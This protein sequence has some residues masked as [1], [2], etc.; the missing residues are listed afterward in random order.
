MIKRAYLSY[1]SIILI[2]I[3]SCGS[4]GS[5]NS[6]NISPVESRKEL[7]ERL[8]LGFDDFSFLV[9]ERYILFHLDE[10]LGDV[11][12]TVSYIDPEEGDYRSVEMDKRGGVYFGEIPY[13]N[14]GTEAVVIPYR[15]CIQE[16]GGKLCF[17]GSKL[18][19]PKVNLSSESVK[20]MRFF[21]EY[22]NFSLK[23]EW[24][25]E[26]LDRILKRGSREYFEFYKGYPDIKI[27]VGYIVKNSSCW[28][29]DW[30]YLKNHIQ[31]CGVKYKE[32]RLEI[33]FDRESGRIGVRVI[34]IH[35][36]TNSDAD[37]IS[38]FINNYG[39]IEG[40]NYPVY[41][42]SELIYW[43]DSGSRKWEPYLYYAYRIMDPLEL[44]FRI[45][46]YPSRKGLFHFLIDMYETEESL[47]Y[48]M[49]SEDAVCKK[50]K[51]VINSNG[52]IGVILNPT[53]YC[54]SWG[55]A[56]GG[57]D[58]RR[59]FRYE[60]GSRCGVR[61]Y[62]SGVKPEHRIIDFMFPSSITEELGDYKFT[63]FQLVIPY[64][65][66]KTREDVTVDKDCRYQFR[67]TGY[68]TYYV[69]K[70][71][72]VF[73]VPYDPELKVEVLK[74]RG[75]RRYPYF[76]EDEIWR[77]KPWRYNKAPSGFHGKE[78][79]SNFMVPFAI[80]FLDR[81][82]EE[83]SEGTHVIVKLAESDISEG[84]HNHELFIE[85]SSG[86]G[87]NR[88][89]ATGFGGG[90]YMVDCDKVVWEL[91]NLYH[92]VG[93]RVIGKPGEVSTSY[94]EYGLYTRFECVI[95]RDGVCE[96][97]LGGKK[98]ARFC[99]VAGP[100]SGR[101]KL[102]A[103]TLD[104]KDKNGRPYQV[105]KLIEV[106]YHDLTPLTPEDLKVNGR[107]IGIR[108]GKTTEHPENFYVNS[109]IYPDVLFFIRQLHKD[110]YDDLGYPAILKI[111]D[112][113]LLWGGRFHISMDDMWS[114]DQ[115]HLSH[116][117]GTGMDILPTVC[118]PVGSIDVCDNPYTDYRRNGCIAGSV[119]GGEHRSLI[120]KFAIDLCSDKN[121]LSGKCYI[122]QEPSIHIEFKL[123]R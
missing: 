14:M 50:K 101:Y 94:G 83:T 29:S 88:V 46:K 109:K 30:E 79:A 21:E 25:D 12:V 102:S 98:S 75:G 15:V 77:L 61:E 105:S 71:R 74:G 69:V 106:R 23:P 45:K 1:L 104:A 110:L 85:D 57:N 119:E 120:K 63:L 17:L 76:R 96:V 9:G 48:Y 78:D 8:A 81:E 20:V 13:E 39:G 92:K 66:T 53:V 32:G 41:N 4:N 51:E 121:Q 115:G 5:V 93:K 82:N 47:D 72:G 114:Y 18:F 35:G 118:R 100:V 42:Y 62:S 116:R 24:K 60:Y 19:T 52:I 122:A 103:V 40:I 7:L 107:C 84:G 80:T 31:E 43:W 16:V 117:M 28:G 38:T 54:D 49:R 112:I 26:K 113:S 37:A 44:A 91:N 2:F 55:V 11:G 36:M 22:Y 73:F 68:G 27:H 3:S 95:N 65:M 64:V 108:T 111:N 67:Y 33:F 89:K 34:N 90:I 6:G 123:S 97:D 10:G 58:R 86:E 70:P 87:N 99:Y 56:L 59:S